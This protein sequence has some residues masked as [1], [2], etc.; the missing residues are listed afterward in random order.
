MEPEIRR[1]RDVPTGM[2][3]LLRMTTFDT[4]AEDIRILNDNGH[5]V[6]S[7]ILLLLLVLCGMGVLN[8]VPRCLTGKSV[9]TAHGLSAWSGAVLNHHQMLSILAIRVPS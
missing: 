7:G 4:W 9:R 3:T 8:M 1:F 6:A 2:F 5:F